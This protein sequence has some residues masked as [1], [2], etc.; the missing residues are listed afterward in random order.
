[1]EVKGETFRDTHTLCHKTILKCSRSELNLPIARGSGNC[2]IELASLCPI[3]V[4]W[5]FRSSKLRVQCVRLSV[6][7]RRVYHVSLMN[8][9]GPS[10]ALSG[11]LHRGFLHSSKIFCCHTPRRKRLW[12]FTCNTGRDAGKAQEV[13]MVNTFELQRNGEWKDGLHAAGLQET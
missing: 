7:N 11:L 6:K 10:E 1:M 2:Q 13:F 9:Q 3:K 8:Y 4:C 12:T 5:K